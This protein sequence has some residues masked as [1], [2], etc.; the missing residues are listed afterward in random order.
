MGEVIEVRELSK[1]YGGR[2]LFERLSF[3]VGDGE[4]MVVIGPNGVGKSTLLKIIAGLVRAD[5]GEV[6]ID[7]EVVEGRRYVPPE[8]RGVGYVPQSLGLFPHLTAFENAIFGLKLKRVKDFKLVEELFKAFGIE[9]VKDKYPHQL[10]GGQRQRVA[11]I[12]A[13]AIR[14]R[15]LLLDE[16]LSA[17]DKA[18]VRDLVNTVIKII[19]EERIP[20][21]WVTHHGEV[22]GDKVL[23]FKTSADRQSS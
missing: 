8:R 10:S 21:L 9:E 16:P 19:R 5:E 1:R 14:P 12:R 15:A 20:T 2:T 23:N 7:G 3:T 13:L 11:I 22:R 17:V 4:I 6:R 18:S